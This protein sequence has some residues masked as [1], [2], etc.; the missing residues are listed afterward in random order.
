MKQILF[1]S[2]NRAKLEQFQY[3]A[4]AYGFNVK[5]ASVY[6]KFSGIK[7]YFEEYETQFEI[8][9]KGA[10]EIYTQTKQPIVVE[11]TIL[12][13]DILDGLPGLHANNYLKERGRAG[14][15]EDLKDQVERSARIISIVGYFD[16]KLFI[17]SKNV[18]EGQ[19]AERESFKDGE[20]IWVGPT[21]H[22]FGGGFNSVFISGSSGKTLADHSA[23]EGLTYGYREPNFKIIL[24][25]LVQHEHTA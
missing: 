25:L 20:P 16:G 23:K 15:L 14:L 17:S 1:A 12:E 13:V 19:I 21:Y 3:V 24:D 22:P 18:I 11:D 2:S 8:V 4:D 5:I 9:E 10:R 6:E 7:P